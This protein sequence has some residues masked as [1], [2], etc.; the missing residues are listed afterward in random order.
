V[1][2]ERSPGDV[3]SLVVVSTLLAALAVPVLMALL[4][5]ESS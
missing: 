2:Y 3:A 5:P 4:L 1:R